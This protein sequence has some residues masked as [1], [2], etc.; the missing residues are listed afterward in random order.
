MQTFILDLSMKSVIPLLNAKQRNVGAKIC[1]VLTDNQEAYNIPDNT[2]FSVWFAG[3][4]GVGNYDKIDGR[5]AFTIEGN[6]VTVELIYQMLNMPGEHALCLVMNDNNG[7]QSALWNIPYFVEAI[8]GA[9]S[10]AATD[11]YNA[12][13]EAQQR[14]EQAAAAAENAAER[15]EKVVGAAE[16]AV[17]YTPQDLTEE[18]KAQ[19]QRNIGIDKLC[20]PLATSGYTAV[21]EPVEGYP[22]EVVSHLENKNLMQLDTVERIEDK[23]YW[24]WEYPVTFEGVLEA[25][26]TVSCDYSQA[27]TS[28]TQYSEGA[29]L[30]ELIVDGEAV[31]V[32]GCNIDKKGFTV[33]S[34]TLTKIQ[35]LN[36]CEVKGTV[37]LQLEKGT[38]ATPY[39]P[40]APF[41][42]VK[43]T[44]RG[45][46]L[47][48]LTDR[49]VCTDSVG[50]NTAKRT[51]TGNQIFVGISADN[52][53]YSSNIN[54]YA[55]RET[56]VTV[57]NKMNGYGVGFDIAVS[58]GSTY[59]FSVAEK[60]YEIRHAFYKA[61][62][63]PISYCQDSFGSVVCTA[64]DNARW[65]ML[66]LMPNNGMQ[67]TEL[68][69]TNLQFE[70]GSTATAYEP[71]REPTVYTKGLGQ[72]VYGGHLN[73]NTGVLTIDWYFEE[74]DGVNKKFGN[75]Y[76]W[77]NIV[78]YPIT[79]QYGQSYALEGNIICSHFVN[80]N[81]TADKSCY[82]YAGGNKDIIVSMYDF[83]T[84][85]EA[86]AW[87]VEQKNNGTPLTF[88]YELYEPITIQ[89]TPQDIIALSGTNI[90][91][92]DTGITEVTGRA[93]PVAIINNLQERLAALEKAV[94]NNA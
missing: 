2:K 71:Y 55:V 78:Q 15:A 68:T 33:T 42:E 58:P 18:Q 56:S 91:S 28:T 20:P 52:Y 88:C 6:K 31:Y 49:V 12:F 83:A 90:L 17:T 21:C 65:A 32:T 48:N 22:L 25:P 43:L 53:L 45:K 29:A 26:F 86:N 8:P 11:Y 27:D 84:L 41:T 92:S 94:V 85:D 73:W 24:N 35:V 9:D 16:S 7:H 30:L 46:N 23:G 57:S 93:N 3:K 61:D 72:D 81:S 47:L 54:S 13:L 89:L 40:H 10:E 67:N 38:T 19:A 70:L 44:Q 14:A 64:P 80:R 63:T 50:S 59:T 36:W 82:S 37:K 62:G 5:S 75:R 87:L 39:V 1:V 66:I 74:I 60:S 77:D 79:M 69:Y 76:A 34:G 4:S 51:L